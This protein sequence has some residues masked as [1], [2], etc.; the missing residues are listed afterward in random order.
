MLTLTDAFGGA[1]ARICA[2]NGKLKPPPPVAMAFGTETAITPTSCTEGGR[3]SKT[4]TPPAPTLPGAALAASGP[5]ATGAEALI[6]V[7]G[8][9]VPTLAD[10]EIAGAAANGLADGEEAVTATGRPGAASTAGAVAGEGSANGGGRGGGGGSN[11]AGGFS[12]GGGS[13]C[14]G[15]G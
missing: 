3:T 4:E 9:D 10:G 14:G 13:G 1:S 15:T 12:R 5:E 11:C 2:G 7:E 8:D 6:G